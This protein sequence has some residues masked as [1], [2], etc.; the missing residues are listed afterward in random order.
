M[1]RV[2]VP[3]DGSPSSQR[4]IDYM[5]QKR[6]RYRD[7]QEVEVHLLN[8]QHPFPGDVT[9]FVDHDEIK[10]YHHDKGVKVLQSARDSLDQAG[11]PFI[12]HIGVGDPAQIIAHYAHEKQ[13][14]QIIMGTRGHG[15]IAGLLVGSVATKV[16]H[17]TDVPVLLVK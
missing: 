12:F 7:P 3:V 15:A 9:M 8:V 4:A 13:C 16:L 11:V 5:I 6:G 14:D 2:L 1:R 10:Q 17:L